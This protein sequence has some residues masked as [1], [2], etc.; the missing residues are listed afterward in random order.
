M[1]SSGSPHPAGHVPLLLPIIYF[2]IPTY[3]QLCIICGATLFLL[4][5]GLYSVRAIS[6]ALNCVL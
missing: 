3:C 4:Y 5:H 1:L 2:L 6:I